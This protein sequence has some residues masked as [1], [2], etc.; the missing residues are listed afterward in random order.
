MQAN[1]KNIYRIGCG[2]GCANSLPSL[3]F[4][5]QEAP[6]PIFAEGVGQVRRIIVLG[7][8]DG[9]LR[10]VSAYRSR[11]ISHRQFALLTA[12]RI[13]FNTY[14]WLITRTTKIGSELSPN[15]SMSP[16][17]AVEG[18]DQAKVVHNTEANLS[19]EKGA[20]VHD[21]KSGSIQS[22]QAVNPRAPR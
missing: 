5:E 19:R 11:A 6:Q 16:R 10:T 4:V 12:R 21:R 20:T 9:I 15:E 2:F 14:G 22:G 18:R 17:E 1:A 3:R 8:R 13:Q 7:S